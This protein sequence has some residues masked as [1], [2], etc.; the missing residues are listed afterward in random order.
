[1]QV[2]EGE[3]VSGVLGDPVET[4]GGAVVPGWW[5]FREWREW[6]RWRTGVGGSGCGGGLGDR[7]WDHPTSL[8]GW[9]GG[10]YKGQLST[11][12]RLLAH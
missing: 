9:S 11:D 5:R 7:R 1:M 3:S 10:Y 6:V 8:P 2:P 12:V 4:G